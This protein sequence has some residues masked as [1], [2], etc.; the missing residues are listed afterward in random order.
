MFVSL[1][2]EPVSFDDAPCGTDPVSLIVGLSSVCFDLDFLITT[3]LF[4]RCNK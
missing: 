4:R 1:Q 3:L 2:N